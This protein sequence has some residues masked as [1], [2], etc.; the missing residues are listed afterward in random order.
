VAAHPNAD[1]LGRL[2]AAFGR[3]DGAAVAAIFDHEVVW[4]VGGS[5]PMTGEYRGLREVVRFLQR[6]TEETDGTYRS[7][8]GWALADDERGVAVYR[9]RGTRNGRT[10]DIEIV[11]LCG[12]RLGRITDV[13]AMP[14]DS[15]AFDAF[16]S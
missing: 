3:R 5:N 7:D 13:T 1:L 15:E 8:L 2:F 9:A 12:F 11:L 14:V 10:S 16:W 4:R 6:T